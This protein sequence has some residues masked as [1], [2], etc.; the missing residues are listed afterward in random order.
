VVA[1][2]AATLEGRD[3]H[4]AVVE[5]LSEL[6][7]IVADE[8]ADTGQYKYRYATLG[9]IMGVVRPVLARHGLVVTQQL[10]GDQGTVAVQTVLEHASGAQ[11]ASGWLVV[12]APPS[13]QQLG[14]WV[15]YLRRYQLV[16]LLGL[17]IEDD[18]GRSA[19]APA[20]A[21]PPQRVQRPQGD[22][23]TDAQRTLIRTLF[24]QLGMEGAEYADERAAL[25][26]QVTG[27]RGLT[28]ASAADL[29]AHL[30]DRV[31]DLEDRS[32]SY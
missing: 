2:T 8:T 16:A 11:H 9:R 19:G 21:Q 1:V 32:G 24:S 25:V 6:T 10:A 13:A 7:E 23:M 31:H 18:D 28:T 12:A 15:S 27:D 30:R 14:S 4:T 29:I 5:A 3:L 17:A 26:A 20:A 22:P